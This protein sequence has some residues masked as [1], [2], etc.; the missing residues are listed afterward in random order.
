ML[1]VASS[2]RRETTFK[3]K[4]SGYAKEKGTHSVGNCEM[5]EFQTLLGCTVV[6][7]SLIFSRAQLPT[8]DDCNG[9]ADST[10]ANCYKLI[11]DRVYG[12]RG[13]FSGGVSAGQ[14]LCGTGFE[15]CSNI[16]QMESLGLNMSICGAI[17]RNEELF[18]SSVSSTGSAICS[19]LE[20]PVGTNDV[21][22]CAREDPTNGI[23]TFEDD[24]IFGCGDVLTG[25][26]STDAPP[27]A[28]WS[29]TDSVDELNTIS[30]SSAANGGVLCC[31][32]PTPSPSVSPS[33][34]PSETPTGSPSSSP[35]TS[36]PT[37]LSPTAS[38][39]SS[40]ARDAMNGVISVLVLAHL[41][42]L[43]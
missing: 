5:A 4:E 34:S 19:L 15:I 38:P 9:C 21:W 33:T 1:P 11:A 7:V 17:P 16:P 20:V 28:G 29:A 31:P 36:A 30:L 12:C 27:V 35:T 14:S 6:L 24:A 32:I 40:A 23:F 41:Y 13:T 43:M 2:T 10:Q 42:A 8:Q 22:G 26:W 18:V 37:T 25:F 39:N 3:R